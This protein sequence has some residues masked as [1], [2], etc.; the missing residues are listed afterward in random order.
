MAMT[1]ENG[2]MKITKHQLRKII[3]EEL[4]SESRPTFNITVGDIVRHK[5][6]AHLGVGRVVAKSNKRD[7]QI[8]VRWDS[9]MRRHDPSALIK[10]EIRKLS[11][12][13]GKKKKEQ[14]G[15]RDPVREEDIIGIGNI[16]A[17][18]TWDGLTMEIYVDDKKA[19]SIHDK[20]SAKNF[21]AFL[22]EIIE[23]PMRTSG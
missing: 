8:S 12:F 10:E 22:N 18:W 2:K 13:W 3:R 4:F 23:G 17:A 11:E 14:S 15:P 1:P 20:K 9:G 6:D 16:K 5:D 21:V 19:L 7:R